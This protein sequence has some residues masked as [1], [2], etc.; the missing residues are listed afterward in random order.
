[1]APPVV[2]VTAVGCAPGSA[3]AR[4]LAETGRFRVLGAD[5]LPRC[6][7]TTATAAEH[8]V[9]PPFAEEEAYW[10]FVERL[11]R[12]EGVT[13]AFPTH[14]AEMGA[15]ARRAPGLRGVRVMVNAP[16]VVALADDKRLTY[17]WA[18][19]EGVRVPEETGTAPC[20]SRPRTGCGAEGVLVSM[21]APLPASGD[22]IVQRFVDGEEFTVD[23]L[24]T[25]EGRTVIAVPKR[26][27]R[28]RHGQAVEAAVRMDADVIAFATRVSEAL[29]N[30]CAINV[31]VMR[32]R[33]TGALFLIEINPRFPSSLPLTVRAGA[34]LPAMLV[35][36][37][38]APPAVRDGLGM[39]RELE[40]TFYAASG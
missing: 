6:A 18:L 16:G 8:V 11:V 12:E 32:E 26:R 36:G 35:D 24:A 29:G 13:H 30:T 9:C 7:A 5:V 1:M 10:A 15:W 34:N 23:V 20:V 27:V 19:R 3:V 2:L 25:P 39:L 4:A 33:G 31:Q 28:V 17:E 14:A 37:D 22:R 21:D 40:A 38:V